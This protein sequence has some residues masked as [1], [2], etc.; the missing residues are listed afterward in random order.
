[1]DRFGDWGMWGE[2]EGVAMGGNELMEGVGGKME[3]KM[4]VVKK[5]M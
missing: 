2:G 4:I 1:M 5:G 3:V